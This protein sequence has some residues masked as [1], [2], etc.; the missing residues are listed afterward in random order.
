[1][2]K[3]RQKVVADAKLGETGIGI[4]HRCERSGLETVELLAYFPLEVVSFEDPPLA[5]NGNLLAMSAD[6]NVERAMGEKIW[7]S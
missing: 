1:M 7:D 2:E 4:T 6:A 3:V 5:F